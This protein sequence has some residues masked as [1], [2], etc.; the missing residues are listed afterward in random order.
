MNLAASR[1]RGQMGRGEEAHGATVETDISQTKTLLAEVPSRGK[2]L[3]H[4]NNLCMKV[5]YTREIPYKGKLYVGTI[6]GHQIKD[7]P[8]PPP[9]VNPQTELRIREPRTAD[10][11]SPGELPKD[12]G[13]PPLNK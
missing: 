5:P 4:G 13:I 12:L 9:T 2:S 10:S 8:G 3:V 1:D 6:K 7:Y 11:K